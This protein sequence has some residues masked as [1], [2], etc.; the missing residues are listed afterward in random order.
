MA[1]NRVSVDRA[2]AW[3]DAA[4]SRLPTEDTAVSAAYGRVLGADVRA[5]RPIPVY[6]VAAL[7]GYAVR[8]E[9]SVGAGAYNPLAVPL[10]T[11]SAGDPI[12]EGT[13]AVAPIG[14]VEAEDGSI[15]LS[16][17]LAPGDN[18]SAAGSAAAAGALLAAAGT[19]LLPHHIGLFASAGLVELAVVR[20]PRARLAFAGSIPTD[21]DADGPMLRAALARDGATVAAASFADALAE[22]DAD[23]VLVVGGTGPGPDD[24]SAAALAAA[25]ELALHGVALR[26]GETAGFGRTAAGLPA[27][28][29]PGAPADCLWAYELF[30]GRAVRRL[31]GREPALPY[32]RGRA[33]LAR[34]LV[35]VIGITEI[36]PVR[37]LADREVEP[38]SS[39]AEIGLAA[40]A[41]TDGFV[42]V[43]EASE[44]WPRGAAVEVYWH[45]NR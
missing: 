7:D 22:P 5:P 35:S 23:L 12:P 36:C 34:K 13:D 41:G 6:A 40:V 39:F 44:G 19:L 42:V 1:F 31:A 17:P 15:L 24:R 20:K 29:L 45:P 18:L 43:P 25:G 11:V 38:L 26:P 16:A 33:A 32:R 21:G 2:I 4:T 10:I 37:R 3:V 30:A 8:A 27:L 28:L 9:E 14:Q